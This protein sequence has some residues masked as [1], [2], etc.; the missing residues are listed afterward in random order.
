VV[1]SRSKNSFG[2]PSARGDE[3][4]TRAVAVACAAP[5]AQ[6][7]EVLPLTAPPRGAGWPGV[8]PAVYCARAG[9]RSASAEN[10]SVVARIVGR[11]QGGEG[12]IAA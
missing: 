6:P 7:E 5:G 10:S 12:K 9:A 2:G 11:V 1:S 8:Q 3:G 4:S